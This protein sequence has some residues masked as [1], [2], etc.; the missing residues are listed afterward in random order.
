MEGLEPANLD[1]VLHNAS[2]TDTPRSVAAG[3]V[4]ESAP[5]CVCVCARTYYHALKGGGFCEVSDDT[6]G[7]IPPT[8]ASNL[9]HEKDSVATPYL[10]PAI[11][12]CPHPAP[13][14]SPNPNQ[15]PYRVP[16]G[17]NRNFQSNIQKSRYLF[18]SA[19]VVRASTSQEFRSRTAC[20]PLACYSSLSCQTVIKR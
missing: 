16:T 5:V 11:L 17:F 18:I 15:I 1:M 9:Q 10:P 4:C 3:A 8:S 12:R 19:A 14:C 2:V 13:N 20:F 7:V 6:A